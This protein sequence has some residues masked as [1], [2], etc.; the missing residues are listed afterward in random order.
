MKTSFTLRALGLWVGFLLL[1][2][3]SVARAVPPEGAGTPRA[4]FTP[5]ELETML[6]QPVSDGVWLEEDAAL[7]ADLSN[8]VR[9]LEEDDSPQ[10]R[11]IATN[12]SRGLSQANASS[13]LILNGARVLFLAD[14]Q[15]SA[16]EA[17]RP[18]ITDMAFNTSLPVEE[19]AMA[20]RIVGKLIKE[21]VDHA[22]EGQA[23]AAALV[24]RDALVA[25]ILERLPTAESPNGLVPAKGRDPFRVAAALALVDLGGEKAR[26]RIKRDFWPAVHILLHIPVDLK[27]GFFGAAWDG[28]VRLLDDRKKIPTPEQL[29]GFLWTFRGLWE[30]MHRLG[31]V[32]GTHAD[33]FLMN[34]FAGHFKLNASSVSEDEF[35][36]FVIVIREFIREH[37]F[38]M[39]P[40]S[41]SSVAVKELPEESA[42][43][44]REF[45]S[46][47]L[48]NVIV[49]LLD[50]DEIRPRLFPLG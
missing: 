7:P 29:E 38:R 43:E 11:G 9:L 17:V 49:L 22:K 10:I 18:R 35:Q 6:N 41:E 13:R 15:H 19:Q 47:E 5:L 27:Q 36:R 23:K 8:L 21:K 44:G 34:A 42:R 1:N 3:S 33:E 4:A 2:L 25:R 26:S 16:L 45:F 24:D 31:E 12:I 37:E 50:N 46:E 39:H 28:L 30:A 48:E 14:P 20:M 40:A 32:E